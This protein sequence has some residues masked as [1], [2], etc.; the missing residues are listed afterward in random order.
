L[1]L[2]DCFEEIL[3]LFIFLA[4][5]WSWE[6]HFT[7]AQVAS[8]FIDVKLSLSNCANEKHEDWFKVKPV[9]IEQWW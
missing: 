3:T 5:L 7:V 1:Y 6:L 2:M 8:H 9:I 4:S